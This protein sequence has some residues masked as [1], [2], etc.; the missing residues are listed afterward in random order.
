MR[1]RSKPVSHGPTDEAAQWRSA[2]AL[3]QRMSELTIGATSQSVALT[4]SAAERADSWWEAR[5]GFDLRGMNLL[6]FRGFDLGPVGGF[7]EPTS[8][9]L[10]TARPCSS[11]SISIRTFG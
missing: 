11:L 9:D 6:V 10:D 7:D 1:I 8:L 4:V 5:V 3:L 2:V